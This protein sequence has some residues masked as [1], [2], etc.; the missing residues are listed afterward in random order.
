MHIEILVII[1]NT[2]NALKPLSN[3]NIFKYPKL[4]L[5]FLK[6]LIEAAG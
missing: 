4:N 5:S 6:K 1:P 2:E 3:D